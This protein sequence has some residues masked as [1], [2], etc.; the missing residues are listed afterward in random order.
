MATQAAIEV[1]INSDEKRLTFRL[2]PYQAGATWSK[3][4]V[5]SPMIKITGPNNYSRKITVPVYS[6]DDVP[7]GHS[8]GEIK[9]TDAKLTADG[10]THGEKYYITFYCVNGS[11]VPDTFDKTS[12]I[13]TTP[14]GAPVLGEGEWSSPNLTVNMSI[15]DLKVTSMIVDVYSLNDD[16][17]TDKELEFV[18]SGD[19][20]DD[21]RL[22]GF[23]VFNLETHL[24]NWTLPDT[25]DKIKLIATATDGNDYSDETS[26][27]YELIV[28]PAAP[29]QFT[30]ADYKDLITEDGVVSDIET[31]KYLIADVTVTVGQVFDRIE[32]LG[33]NTYEKYTNIIK[34]VSYDKS[35]TDGKYSNIKF[36]VD[37]GSVSK[38]A[39]RIVTNSVA[40][41]DKVTDNYVIDKYTDRKPILSAEKLESDNDAGHEASKYDL[42]ELTL[43]A[44]LSSYDRRYINN[45]QVKAGDDAAFANIADNMLPTSY[46]A[47]KNGKWDVDANG[48]A[49]FRVYTNKLAYGKSAEFQIAIGELK[50]FYTELQHKI[51]GESSAVQNLNA[52]VIKTDAIKID[53]PLTVPDPVSNVT[54]TP[55]NGGL[56]VRWEIAPSNTN[57]LP[58][59]YVVNIYGKEHYTHGNNNDIL[60]TQET[61][62]PVAIFAG[63][64]NNQTYYA[65]VIAKNDANGGDYSKP[66]RS[67]NNATPLA[68]MLEQLLTVVE[69]SYDDPNCIFT[70]KM[71]TPP[72]EI[73]FIDVQEVFL[74]GNY[75]AITKHT[76]NTTAGGTF[77]ISVDTADSSDGE[78]T[79][80][81]KYFGIYA[82]SKDVKD[83]TGS[84]VTPSSKSTPILVSVVTGAPPKILGN[85]TFLQSLN[86]AGENS[87][88][89]T[90]DVLTGNASTTVNLVAIPSQSSE[91]STTSS[92]IHTMK[93]GQV[94]TGGTAVR[95]SANIPY[96]FAKSSSGKEVVSVIAT[97]PLGT[98]I[99]NHFT[100]TV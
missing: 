43:A 70:V 58:T 56:W 95:H 75:G 94:I 8:V 48:S 52:A 19:Q 81:T 97:N 66:T 73:A 26:A 3:S 80:G 17:T 90:V 12:V 91:A 31:F 29:T 44:G 27:D 67:S 14:T 84:I 88:K 55:V 33:P 68:N 100:P 93:P 49:T 79:Y 99:L 37:L 18:L 59:S 63:L 30:V 64:S 35:I 32:I 57:N 40:S 15:P 69:T 45:L 76:V 36:S 7:A 47:G 28:R 71:D 22:K 46:V 39:A 92:F 41:I 1:E 82:E 98:H 16:D 78:H 4:D 13:I 2:T 24:D 86:A 6:A 85:M 38:Y 21:L 60:Y 25:G 61:T 9:P 77:T 23:H 96:H 83:S 34:S 50:G 72:V 5:K 11:N 51:G 74:D 54:M 87:T 62:V 65:S 42:F 89:V 10:V 20:I 53:H